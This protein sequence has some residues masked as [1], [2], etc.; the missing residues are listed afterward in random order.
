[1][2]G[3]KTV[4]PLP[5]VQRPVSGVGCQDTSLISRIHLCNRSLA[6][7]VLVALLPV[8]VEDEYRQ[9]GIVHPVLL[10]QAEVVVEVPDHSITLMSL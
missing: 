9:P 10:V 4:T 8:A 5:C 2:S 1:M 3:V 7:P 6:I